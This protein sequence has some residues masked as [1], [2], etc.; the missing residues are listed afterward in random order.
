MLNRLTLQTFQVL[1]S[2]INES[3]GLQKVLFTSPIFT[4]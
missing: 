1:V 4:Q 2:K 3:L